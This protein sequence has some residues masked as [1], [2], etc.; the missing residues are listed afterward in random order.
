M[1]A[2][3]VT[4]A[5]EERHQFGARAGAISANEICSLVEIAMKASPGEVPQLRKPSM[6]LGDNMFK[7][8]SAWMETFGKKA[9]F[10]AIRRTPTY[11]VPHPFS[12]ACVPLPCVSSALDEL[13]SGG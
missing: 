12:H 3:F 6:L 8:E 7:G 13:S 1:A 10:A 11:L 2:P 4:T 9:V 5:I